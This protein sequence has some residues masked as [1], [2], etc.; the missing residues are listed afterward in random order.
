MNDTIV[1]IATSL[2]VG[3]ISI[4]KVSGND[5]I[6][7]VNKIFKGHNLESANSHTIHYGHIVDNEEI[8]DEVL[9]SIMRS[10]KT[11]T[12]E[13]VVEINCHGG[14]ATTNKVLE[15]LI[16]NG[17][18]MAEPGEFTKRAFLNGR[19]DLIEAEAVSD[20]INSETELERKV[21]INGINGNLSNL[22][23]KLRQELIDII[24]NIEVNIDY[25]EYQDIYEVTLKDIKKKV[26][27]IKKELQKIIDDYE[28][29]HLL[30]QGINV[31]IVGRPNVGKSSLLNKLLDSNKAIVTNIPG[32]TRDIVEGTMIIDGIKIHL[33]D[34]AGIRETEDVVEKIGVEKSLDAM[35]NANL[36]LM[37]L[38][39]N[40]DLTEKDQELIKKCSKPTIFVINKND[41]KTKI[42]I[43]KDL[44]NID[45]NNIISINTIDNKGIEIV[46]NKI[47]ELFKFDKITN[48]DFTYITNL[49]QINEIKK[50]LNLLIELE[51]ELDNCQELDMLEIDLKEIWNTLGLIIGES[52][53]EELLDNLFKN[54]CVGK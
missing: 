53:E 45:K 37:V 4:I 49:R 28:N 54:F 50:S 42:K 41:L 15:L 17:C 3:A 35:N 22:I 29:S 38:N 7:I 32:T 10:P 20:L 31:A 34:T 40:E 18:R 14:I 36:I 43:D 52:Y 9:V 51:K 8:I 25:P 19:I 16:K 11:Y 46:K 23:K 24:S 26:P 33:I 13:D 39:N 44:K 1:S 6:A 27:K 47:R 21:A 2:G 5:S 48:G 12:C 30:Y